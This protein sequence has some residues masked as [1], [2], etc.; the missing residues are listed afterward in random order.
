MTLKNK[1]SKHNL[2]VETA[3]ICAFFV[4][5]VGP[6]KY[7]ISKQYVETLLMH[8]KTYFKGGQTLKLG[9]GH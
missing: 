1:K 9:K 4:T 2:W 5:M 3:V 6:N 8:Q 7:G